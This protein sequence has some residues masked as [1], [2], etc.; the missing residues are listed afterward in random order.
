MYLRPHA[1]RSIGPNIT[2]VMVLKSA[3]ASI[4]LIA[5]TGPTT[6]LALR[7]GKQ[8]EKEQ[9]HGNVMKFP[10]DNRY[11]NASMTCSCVTRHVQ[12]S[13]VRALRVI[14]WLW[15]VMSKLL[16][17]CLAWN[18]TDIHIHPSSM[19]NPKINVPM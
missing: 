4:A 14:K 9:M 2:A 7:S 19:T 11:D 15:S 10:N 1:I 12:Q 6:R 16:P 13:I 5:C 17:S 18:I 8:E 3:C